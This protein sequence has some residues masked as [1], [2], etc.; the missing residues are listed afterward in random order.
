MSKLVAILLGAILVAVP[1]YEAYA[2]SAISTELAQM[3]RQE[4]IAAHPTPRPGTANKGI[5]QAQR[6]FFRACVANYKK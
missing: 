1:G 5:K 3:C 2:R 4:A 6:E